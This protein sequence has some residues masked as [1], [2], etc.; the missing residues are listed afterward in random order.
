MLNKNENFFAGLDIGGST[1]KSILVDQAGQQAGDMIEAPSHVTD[2]FETT[3]SQ[4]ESAL[5]SLAKNAGLSQT[6]IKGVGMDVPAPNSDG[7][8]WKKSN[9]ADDWM[10][11]NIRDAFSNKIGLPVYMTNDCNA[12]AMG[13]FT[14][15]GENKT[16]LLYVAPGTGFG[17]GLVLPGGTLYEGANGLALEPG[18]VALPFREEDGSLPKCACGLDGCI[19]A[20]VSLIALRRRLKIELSKDKWANH[21]FNNENTPIEKKAFQLRDLAENN[22]ALAVEI[23]KKQGYI[24]G[25]ALADLV[26]LFDPGLLVIGGGLAETS[27]RDK[28]Q[29]WV[30]EGFEEHGGGV[31]K[32]EG[33]SKNLN[34]QLTRIEWAKAGD[35]AGA[36]GMAFMARE[37]FR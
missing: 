18:H 10:G 12:A 4:L 24:L 1:V 14:I 26:R 31:D 30:Y 35:S 7:V 20:W 37:L 6:A 15:R 34:K 3:F 27:F 11:R 32:G 23:F 22:D 28:Y 21:S 19:E 33:S 13:E 16:G 9:L 5:D 8:I 17:G 29:E 36:L 25:Y 2:G